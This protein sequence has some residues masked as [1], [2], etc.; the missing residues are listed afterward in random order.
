MSLDPALRTR[1]DTL[2]QDNRIVLFM[3]GQPQMPQCG[4]SAKAAGI[5]QGLEVEFAHVDVLS[6]PDIREGIKVYGSWPTIPQ[7]YI[8]GELVGGSDIIE[9]MANSGELNE[10]LGLPPIDRT[11]PRNVTVKPAAAEMLRGALAEAGADTALALS[12]DANFRPNFQVAKASANAIA[13]ETEGLRIQF[14]PASA[15]RAD[16]IT[17]DWVDDMRGKGLAIDNPNAPKPA[18]QL[19]AAE[20]DARVRDGKLT[21]VDVRGADERKVASVGVAHETLEGDGRARLEALP[22]DT[23]IA[24]LCHTGGRSQQAADHFRA[25]GFSDVYNVEGGIEA[26]ATTVDTSLA[27]Y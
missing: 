16:G 23:A 18:R 1:I 25:L 9:E 26:W 12:I 24:F 17:I 5:L 7:L 21:L 27:R 14:D 22:K 6:D 11:P 2:L 13:V 19:S 10:A 15:R 4:F 20:A 8:G 3:K